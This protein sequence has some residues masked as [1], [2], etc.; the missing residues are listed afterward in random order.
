MNP[1]I[2]KNHL[3]GMISTLIQK[4]ELSEFENEIKGSYPDE[5]IGSSFCYLVRN[6]KSLDHEEIKTILSKLPESKFF[7][8]LIQERKEILS[9]YSEYFDSDSGL[10]QRNLTSRNV[11]CVSFLCEIKDRSMKFQFTLQC[12][13]SNS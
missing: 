12:Q 5:F 9:N 1:E 2:E 4:K 10:L 8:Y 6:S 13:L 3:N 7:E 11:F